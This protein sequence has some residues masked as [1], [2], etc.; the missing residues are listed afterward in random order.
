MIWQLWDLGV[1]I[2]LLGLIWK[3]LRWPI[4]N[5]TK[6]KYKGVQFDQKAPF[7]N[8]SLCISENQCM[9]LLDELYVKNGKADLW[10]INFVSFEKKKKLG[11]CTH[12]ELGP[13]FVWTH[14]WH[15]ILVSCSSRHSFWIRLS[16]CLH[17]ATEKQKIFDIL[18]LFNIFDW[19][20]T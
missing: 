12:S 15:G 4:L 13:L 2:V 20:K 18:S 11:K 8:E 9:L 10:S 14:T 5:E 7:H 19:N 16:C 3:A 1:I 17:E 6:T